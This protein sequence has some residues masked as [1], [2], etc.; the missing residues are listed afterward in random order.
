ML[1]Q[2]L[3]VFVGFAGFVLYISAFFFPEVHR[4]NDFLWSGIIFFYALV[5]W[6]QAGRITGGVLLG[7]TAS[8]ILLGWLGWQ[9]LVM[10][11]QLT[12]YDQQTWVS[13]SGKSA[14]EVMFLKVSRWGTQMS[15][16]L[17]RLPL[18]AP[19]RA[20]LRSA[21][22][23]DATQKSAQ[24]PTK[25]ASGKSAEQGERPL[26]PAERKK[27]E[28]A[29]AKAK[30]A[31]QAKAT[32]TEAV[33]QTE[34]APGSAEK[35]AEESVATSTEQPTNEGAEQPKQATPKS[36][37]RKK[38][39]PVAKAPVAPTTPTEATTPPPHSASPAESPV[40]SSVEAP[41]AS[42]PE[43]T[44]EAT[45]EFAGEAIEETPTEAADESMTETANR[46]E[47]PEQLLTGDVPAEETSTEIAEA[48]PSVT[49]TDLTD[50]S[51]IEAPTPE[52]VSP[53][54]EVHTVAEEQVAGDEIG[55]GDETVVEDEAIAPSSELPS[56][57]G[58]VTAIP[59]PMAKQ[60]NFAEQSN[61]DQ[62]NEAQSNEEDWDQNWADGWADD[63]ADDAA[64]PEP[65]PSTD[66]PFVADDEPAP[67][68]GESEDAQPTASADAA[69]TDSLLNDR[70]EESL[71]EPGIEPE[72]DTNWVDEDIANSTLQAPVPKPLDEM[73]DSRAD[74]WDDVP[75][76]AESAASESAIAPD[77]TEADAQGHEEV[78][79]DED[80]EAPEDAPQP[81]QPP[82]RIPEQTPE[83][84]TVP[85]RTDEWESSWEEPPTEAT[86]IQQPA[87]QPTIEP[88]E[89]TID[90]IVAAANRSLSPEDQI[91]VD[92]KAIAIE[93]PR[94]ELPL[95]PPPR[96]QP[97]TPSKSPWDDWD[98][99]DSN[100]AD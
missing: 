91:V 34:E 16:T 96:K 64:T 90:E 35:V 89:P 13:D 33:A 88:D 66:A 80:W 47:E 92:V 24:K 39:K 50:V 68:S 51:P 73:T 10:R 71:S 3:A 82:V 29:K 20:R 54:E 84:V 12:P 67:T 56:Q 86:A 93:S 87:I 63:I 74:D 77:A 6:V 55:V 42:R 28:K 5:L 8:V 21:P 37:K 72:P 26:A 31:A 52:T 11:R 78:P 85:F 40:A 41:V 18:P 32:A 79:W 94:R 97:D 19:L 36:A 30:A 15:G 4:K 53:V 75:L 58:R 22:P 9:T 46:V 17:E 49:P 95:Q 60:P 7:Q 62:R 76:P 70:V 48:S 81:L 27:A 100:W 65:E 14:G 25:K 59:E 83:N 61:T 44:P 23:E 99:E 57:N 69:F 98:D 45:K 2:V 1:A 43:T 38:T